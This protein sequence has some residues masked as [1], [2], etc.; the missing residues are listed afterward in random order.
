MQAE[1]GLDGRYVK[2]AIRKLGRDRGKRGFGN[3]RSV[4]I[5]F[6]DMAGQTLRIQFIEADSSPAAVLVVPSYL[7]RRIYWVPAAT[8]AAVTEDGRR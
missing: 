6:Q 1:D 8:M 5:F 2:A 3:V 7:F 4:E